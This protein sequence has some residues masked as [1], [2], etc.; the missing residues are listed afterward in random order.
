MKKTIIILFSFVISLST[1][2]QQADTI[3]YLGFK[4]F[5]PLR[6]LQCGLWINNAGDIAYKGICKTD[7][8]S[9]DCYTKQIYKLPNNIFDRDNNPVDV[10]KNVVDTASFQKLSPCHFRDKNYHYIFPRVCPIDVPIECGRE[11]FYMNDK[12]FKKMQE[13]L[14]INL[15]ENP[16]EIIIM[17]K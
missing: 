10:W 17:E 6:Q 8:G 5:P 9:V 12:T 14:E 11:F 15:Q 4:D 3:T 16:C 7:T 2:G 1:Y 13:K